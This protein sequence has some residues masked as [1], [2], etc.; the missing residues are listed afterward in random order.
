LLL[1]C[2]VGVTIW[3]VGNI[4]DGTDRIVNLRIPTSQASTA[5]LTQIQAS[6]ANLRGWMLT[7]NGS[8]K[9]GRA[10]VWSNIDRI[11]GDMDAL[12]ET[13]TNPK[14]TESWNEFKAILAEFRMAQKKLKILPIPSTSNRQPRC[15]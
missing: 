3:Q 8:F 14:N 4:K 9:E 15:W 1:G 2:A 5:M 11:S 13:W 6:L 7:G 12:S 10:T